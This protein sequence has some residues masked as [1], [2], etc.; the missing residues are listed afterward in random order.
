MLSAALFLLRPLDE[1]RK[2]PSALTFIDTTGPAPFAGPVSFLHPLENVI[3]KSEE[4]FI[5]T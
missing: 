5:S 2:A 3:G 4:L 1:D